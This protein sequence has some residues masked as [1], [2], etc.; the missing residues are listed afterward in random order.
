M[1]PCNVPTGTLSNLKCN[2]EQLGFFYQKSLKIM[3]LC[4]QKNYFVLT[5]NDH[6]EYF[7]YIMVSLAWKLNSLEDD[8]YFLFDMKNTLQS[9]G[10]SRG[11]YQQILWI[12]W[13]K[14][15]S[16]TFLLLLL[17]QEKMWFM[18]HNLDWPR[19][20]KTLENSGWPDWTLCTTFMTDEIHCR[21]IWGDTC[22]KG[23][24]SCSYA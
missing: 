23:Q 6:P 20:N 11:K 14:A 1:K 19:L 24:F 12:I 16:S 7:S 9:P 2:Y 3:Y 22:W 8:F 15:F 21:Q 13:N 18:W 4:F 5:V 17:F 10:S